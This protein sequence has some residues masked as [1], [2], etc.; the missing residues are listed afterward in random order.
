MILQKLR[1]HARKD[2]TMSGV[3][4]GYVQSCYV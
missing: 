4:Q 1:Y 3:A 2:A